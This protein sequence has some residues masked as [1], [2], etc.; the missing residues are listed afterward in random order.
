MPATSPFLP[1]HARHPHLGWFQVAQLTGCA[2]V[3]TGGELDADATADLDQ[4]LQVAASGSRNV[5]V[6]MSRVVFADSAAMGVLLAA[7]TRAIQA[8]GSVVLVRPPELARRL[9]ANTLLQKAFPVHDTL[10]QA[11]DAVRE[12]GSHPT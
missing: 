10:G 8:G 1:K 11:I 12:G 2:V 7:R 4:A 5:V 9:L 3:S 6:D